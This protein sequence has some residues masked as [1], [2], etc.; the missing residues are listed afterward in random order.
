MSVQLAALLTNVLLA[1]MKFTVGSVANSKAL[2]ADAFNSAGDVV[3]TLVAWL[4]FR[5]GLKPP[6][7]DH[8]YGHAN[9]EAMAGLLIGG[10]LC[11]TGTFIFLNGVLS[12]IEDPERVEPKALALYAAALT[13]VVKEV[14]YRVSIRVGRR[15]NSPTLLASARD[16]RADVV[17][18]LVALGGIWIARNGW[19]EVDS[20]AAGLIGVYIFWLGFEPVRNNTTILMQGAPTGLAQDATRIAAGVEG[21]ARVGLV[22]V[23]PVGGMFRMDMTLEVEGDL[24][25]RE[26][27]EIAH[28]TEAAILEQV[29]LVIEVHVH[30]EP[31]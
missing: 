3:A 9:A 24:T 16:H 2:I 28:R 13:A 29:Q 25:V 18:S 4:A 19:P 8:H 31:S 1:L 20:I 30:V 7:E 15:T 12:L 10:M 6:D 21:V 27:H 22:R 17:S 11:A 14:L 26:A 23:L 5:Y